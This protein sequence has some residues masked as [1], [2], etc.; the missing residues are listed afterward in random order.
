MV[1]CSRPGHSINNFMQSTAEKFCFSKVEDT[2]QLICE[3]GWGSVVDISNA[4]RHV[5]VFSPHREFTGFVWDLGEGPRYYRDNYLCFGLRSAPSIFNSVSNMVVRLMLRMGIQCQGYL[6]DYFLAAPTYPLCRSRQEFLIQLLNNRGFEVNESKVT[7]LS[8][9]PKYFGV[10]IDMESMLFRL[11]EEKLL[12]TSALVSKLLVA[13]YCSRKDLE[14]VTGYLAHVSVLVKGGRTFCRRLYSLLKA[15]TG[16]RRIQF[17]A[18]YRADLI[19]WEKFLR[20]FE[21]HCK[22]FPKSVVPYH[23]FTDSSGSGYGAWYRDKF[24]FGFYSDLMPTHVHMFFPTQFLMMFP[25]HALMLKSYGQWWRLSKGG[26]I[27]GP[28]ME[29]S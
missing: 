5:Q 13:K 4:Y 25:L 17:G 19:W 27:Y 15:T 18:L 6:D 16:K 22:I 24:L 10:I 7:L 14:R 11:P 2:R 12:K 21:G 3:G 28:M 26:V 29:Y 1:D 9:S 20:V 23:V 8:R